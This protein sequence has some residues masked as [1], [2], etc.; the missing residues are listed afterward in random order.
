MIQ[1]AKILAELRAEGHQV[2]DE[3]ASHATPLMRRHINPLGRYLL[4]FNRMRQDLER[5]PEANP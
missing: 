4:D 3:T 2:D 5:G 1:I